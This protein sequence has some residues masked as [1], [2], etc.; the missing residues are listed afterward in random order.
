MKKKILCIIGGSGTGKTFFE[1]TLCRQFPNHY[2]RV[3][4]YTT[5]PMRQGETEGL[6]HHF[7]SKAD[8]PASSHMLAY[9]QYGDYEYWAD[10]DSLASDKINIYVI[11]VEG[12]RYLKHFFGDDYDLRVVYVKRTVRNGIDLQRIQRDRGRMTLNPDDIDCVVRNEGSKID[13]Y[14]SIKTFFGIY[15]TRIFNDNSNEQ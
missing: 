12:Y 1:R 15:L 7:V 9:T 2:A 11:D 3:V 6:E 4:S 10:K 8:R 5:R 13:L 14:N